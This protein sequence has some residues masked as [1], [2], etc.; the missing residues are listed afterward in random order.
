MPHRKF[1]SCIEACNACAVACNHC[2]A[3]CLQEPDVKS[4]ARCIALD[5]DCAEICALAAAAMSR[6][7]ET[8]RIACQA[9]A[10]VCRICGEECARHAMDHCRE[11]AQ[12]CMRCADECRNLAAA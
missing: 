4:M 12:A 2:L 6:G 7:S 11:C 3:A 8:S 5:V 1:E 10:E 9:C